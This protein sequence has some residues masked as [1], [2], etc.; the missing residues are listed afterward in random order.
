MDPKVTI[1][2]PTYNSL[3]DCLGCL[4]SLSKIT[5]PNC[6][7]VVVDDGS[8]DGT[9]EEVARLYPQVQILHGDGNLWWTG[10]MNLGLREAL[11]RGADYCMAM[12]SDVRVAPECV[13]ELVRCAEG[14]KPCIVGSVIYEL[15]EPQRIWCA[16]GMLR[17]PFPG[18]VMLGHGELD[19]GQ[20]EGVREVEWTP[21]MGT[22]YPRQIL[23]ELDCYDAKF[24]Q[25]HADADLTLRA[26]RRGYRVL[27]TSRSRLYNE[28]GKTGGVRSDV[29][30]S[31]EDARIIFFSPRSGDNV[32]TLP[33]FY[34][35]YCPGPLVPVA[36]L[37]RYLSILGFI[38]K[39]T[40]LRFFYSKSLSAEKQ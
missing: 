27:V 1:T 8:T 14:N 22:L 38:A 37:Y 16:G 29:A 12:N 10:C 17:W 35:R 13:G 15:A 18:T 25:Y 3:L 7:V 4:E 32:K 36:L 26:R 24:P 9:A 21:G 39:R 2:V 23:L 5:Y 34:W 31:W 30:L 40:F 28:S 20:L 19:H 6:D 33:R 11:A